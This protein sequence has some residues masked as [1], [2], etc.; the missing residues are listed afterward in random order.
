M[1]PSRDVAKPPELPVVPDE[2]YPD[3][4][5]FARGGLGRILRATDKVMGRTVAIKELLPGSAVAEARF[6]REALITGRLEHP[7]IVPVYQAGRWPSGEPFYTMKLVSGR[8][9]S[10]IV[11]STKTLA[12]RLALIPA[13]IDV[14]QAIAYAHANGAIHRDIKPSNVIVGQFGETMVIDWGLAKERGGD[15][16]DAPA[17]PAGGSDELTS[18]GDVLGTPAYMAPEQAKGET[19]DERA[20][21]YALGALLY[22]VLAGVPPHEPT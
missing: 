9:L 3:R 13:G 22:F 7:S 18:Y 11:R 8:P 21:V 17:V 2:A 19:V 4:A 10:A 12:E 14:A 6:I 15:D 20:D 5:E 16:S 1:L